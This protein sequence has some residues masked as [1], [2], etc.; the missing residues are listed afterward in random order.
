MS[1]FKVRG[2]VTKALRLEHSIHGVPVCGF[3]LVEDPE[4]APA[5]N[6]L[7]LDVIARGDL[8]RRCAE[9]IAVDRLVEVGGHLGRRE[10]RKGR[11]KWPEFS[12]VA[13]SV[14]ALDPSPEEKAMARIVH[15]K[16]DDYDIY[17]GRGHDP[18][19]GEPGRW[20]NPYSH[21]ASK[22]PGVVRVRSAR[23]AVERYEAWLWE[24]IKAG[25]IDLGALAELHG[26]TLG[27]WCMGVCHGA[28]LARA[29][30]WAHRRV[31]GRP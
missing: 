20:G 21:R 10:M 13:T 5:C 28:V 9:W 26:K 24:Q 23:E 8:A 17:I 12:A 31:E 6:P 18:R 3:H 16:E 1:E 2:T 25:K 11:I 27:C 14:K 4:E 7:R 30:A 29:A 19:S 22:A 15:C